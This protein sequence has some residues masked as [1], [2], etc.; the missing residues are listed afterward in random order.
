VW[1]AS[2][3]GLAQRVFITF[4]PASIY[5]PA[6]CLRSTM[7]A[8]QRSGLSPDRID[9][10]V[11]ES[12]EVKDHKHLRNVLNFYRESGFRV[13]LD[14]L[15]WSYGSLEL[16]GALRPDFIKLD[17]RP[18]QNVDRDPYRAVIASKLLELAK[19][20]G[21]AVVAEGRRDRGAVVVARG[22]RR[23]LRAGLP[24]RPA[25]LPA[26]HPRLRIRPGNLEGIARTRARGPL[27]AQPGRR[28]RLEISYADEGRKPGLYP[29]ARYPQKVER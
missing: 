28:S 13:A 17:M 27:L 29:D 21:V 20:L 15:G 25:R 12:E 26:T 7:G 24:L 16:L 9:F 18:V 5:D 2:E 14:D 3:L 1:E 11:T 8:I 10:E 22:Q 6:Y 19:D 23:G 4:D